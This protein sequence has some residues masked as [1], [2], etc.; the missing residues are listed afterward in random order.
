[1]KHKTQFKKLD[2]ALWSINKNFGITPKSEA[3]HLIKQPEGSA[4]AAYTY[5]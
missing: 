5:K 4:E 1:M 2:V 3:Q